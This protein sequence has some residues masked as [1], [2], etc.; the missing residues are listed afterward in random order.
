M[1]IIN[2]EGLPRE[3]WRT[4][5]TARMLIS[6]IVGSKELCVFEEWC[7]PGT[8]APTHS[9][10]V[11]EVLMVLSGKME[12]WLGDERGTLTKGESIIVP[13][14]IGHGFRNAGDEELHLQAILSASF[15]ETILS[16]GGDVS[17]H[18]DSTSV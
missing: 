14:G 18:W 6:A 5:V 13:A 16:P 1:R 11:E 10:K 15:L 4:G 8:S 17:V 12:V 3:E 9:H 7:A 2:H